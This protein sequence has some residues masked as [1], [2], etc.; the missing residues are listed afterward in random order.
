MVRTTPENVLEPFRLA[1][2]CLYRSERMQI[3]SVSSQF[4]K[5]FVTDIVPDG[6]RVGP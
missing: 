5:S 6:L 4:M 3:E 2:G 1:D